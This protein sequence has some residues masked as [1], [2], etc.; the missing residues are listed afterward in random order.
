MPQETTKL[1]CF[2]LFAQLIKQSNLQMYNLIH[3]TLVEHIL[4]PIFGEKFTEI[5][6][7]MIN[8]LH[9]KISILAGPWVTR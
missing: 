4:L 3:L 7:V 2:F 1:S 8:C 6:E 9:K 5:P